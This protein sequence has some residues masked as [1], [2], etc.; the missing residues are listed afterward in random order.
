[1]ADIHKATSTYES[2]TNDTV[3]NMVDN[4]DDVL[5]VE[6]NGPASAIIQ[7]QTILGLGTT[8]KGSAADLAARLAIALDTDGKLDE[9]S[10]TTKTTWPIPVSECGI[11]SVTFTDQEVLRYD[12]AGDKFESA[13]VTI[14][15]GASGDVAI[16]TDSQTLTNKTL[17]LPVIGDFT[18]ATHD[19]TNAANGGALGT[20]VVGTT[21]LKI[22]AA[23]TW[24]SSSYDGALG[25][26]QTFSVA[27]NRIGDFT[28]TPSNTNGGGMTLQQIHV[29]GNS[30]GDTLWQFVDDAGGGGGALTVTITWSTVG[31]V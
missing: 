27:A 2:G 1:M 20:N 22:E 3:T 23:G 12:N 30:S 13:G 19:H 10:A 4:T 16:V 14:P 18:N 25:T 7:M 11:G 8:L 28:I 24:T 31:A 15:V 6:Q 9:F 21:E 29:A 26:T 5:A 17:T